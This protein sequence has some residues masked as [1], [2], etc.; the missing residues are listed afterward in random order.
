MTVGNSR[1]VRLPDA[2]LSRRRMLGLGGGATLGVL[3][4]GTACQPMT[5]TKKSASGGSKDKTF[6]IYWNPGHVYD[7]YSKV[8]DQFGKD[9]D[10]T[11]NWQKFQWPDL[12]TKLIADFK[13]G[14]VPDLTEDGSA[15]TPVQYGV[16]GNVMA[17]DDFAKKDRAMNFPGDFLE[18]SYKPR[19]YQGKTY[20]IPMHLTAN[21]LLFY[22]KAM[23]SKAGHNTAP[24]TW[25]EFLEVA[26]ATTRDK[27]S[28]M[29]LNADSSYATPWYLQGAATYSD[30]A[31][32]KFMFPEENA[33]KAFGFM[34]DLITKYKVSPAP[35]ATTDYSGPQKLL[36]AKRA[37]MIV[38]GPWDLQP[39]HEGSPDVDL[40]VAAPLKGQTTG[41]GLAGAGLMIP[42]KAK[43]P[44]LAWE[45]ITRLTKLETEL[46]VTKETGVSMPRKSWAEAP[47]IAGD[48]VLKAIAESLK[49]IGPQ[50]VE[51]AVLGRQ[52]QVGD[53]YTKAY[54]QMIIQGKPVAAALDDFRTQAVRALQ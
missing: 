32:K 26:R 27:V 9:H 6:T 18:P 34:Q 51:L 52:T 20:A 47:E 41:S 45:L 3:G 31:N 48:P 33:N 10:L 43:H 50:D 39:I 35:V 36:S 8:I 29:A 23:L 19:Q 42:S 22:N 7:A 2:R 21:G 54:Q 13:S 25:D 44:E 5:P 16:A 49:V 40:G 1:R 12:T 37:A 30:A 53:L 46:A 24:T 15:T 11:I 4:A 38:T 14:N 28:G 17:L